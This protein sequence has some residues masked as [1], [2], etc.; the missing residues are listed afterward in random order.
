MGCGV[1]MSQ[2][3]IRIKGHLDQSWSDWFDG[4]TIQ[5]AEGDVTV[6]HGPIPD[7][8]ALYGLV[9]KA[10][11]IGLALL[12]IRLLENDASADANRSLPQNET[13]AHNT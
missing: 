13:M 12:S 2:V 8:A 5:Y 4:L 9:A 7:Q 11:D 1:K 3:E 10:R 6:M